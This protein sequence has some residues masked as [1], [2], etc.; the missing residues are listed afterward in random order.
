MAEEGSKAAEGRAIVGR[1]ILGT[2]RDIPGHPVLGT[3]E[4]ER[5]LNC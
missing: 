5:D 3:P 1:P 2:G 4:I